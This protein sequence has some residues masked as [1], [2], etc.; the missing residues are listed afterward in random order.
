MNPKVFF[1][2][3][4]GLEIVYG[5]FNKYVADGW[6]QII[7]EIPTLDLVKKSALV[8]SIVG[9]GSLTMILSLLAL[10][11]SIASLTVNLNNNKNKSKPENADEEN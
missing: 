10:I 1:I 2:N 8:G 7:V 11:A 9:E 5:T 6:D 3:N 4:E